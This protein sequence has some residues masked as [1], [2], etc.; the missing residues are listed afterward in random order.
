MK[1]L[2][3]CTANICRS[4]LAE[5]ILKKM[6]QESGVTCIEVESAGVRNLEGEP[7]DTTMAAC[8]YKAG[9]VMNG[10]ARY[11]SHDMTGSTDLIIC[12]E[13]HHIVEIQKRLPYVQWNRIHLFNEICFDEKTGMPDPSGGTIDMYTNAFHRIEDGCRALVLKLSKKT[14]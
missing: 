1:V 2:F 14:E 8:A 5:V 12:M 11:I 7:R 9:Y 6:L 4:A 10:E 3:V 13:H